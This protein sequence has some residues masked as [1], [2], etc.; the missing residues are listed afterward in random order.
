MI[1]T[2]N[3]SHAIN[4]ISLKLNDCSLPLNK[5]VEQATEYRKSCDQTKWQPH[6]IFIY[7]THRVDKNTMI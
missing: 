2:L 1:Q 4:N 5:S 3:E 7:F 6:P